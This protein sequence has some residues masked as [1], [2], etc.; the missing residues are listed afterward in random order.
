MKVLVVGSGGRE[1]A[2]AWK[3]AQSPLINQ[4]YVAP[5]NAG[6]HREPKVQN[7]ALSPLAFD[8]LV[9]FVKQ[10]QIDFTVVGPEAPLVEGI[11][12][13]FESKN[14]RC[15]GPSA[16]CAQLEGSKVFSKTFM[17]QFHIP[18]AK[19][20]TFT[21]AKAAEHYLETVNFPIVIKADG[22]ASGKGVIIAPDLTSA[23]AAVFDMLSHKKFGQA[24]SQIIIED[25]IQ[26]E[27]LS[28][29]VL[30]DGEHYL[31]LATSQD[32]KARDDNDKG[33]NTGGM[34]AYSPAPIANEDLQTKIIKTVIEP[35]LH[36]LRANGTPFKG[37]LYAGLMITAQNDIYVL[38]YNCRFG[39]PE[40]QPILMRLKSDFAQLCL[41]T[42][43]GKLDTY[44][45]QWDSQAALGVVLAANG[46]PDNPHMGDPCPTLNEIAPSDNYKIFH[47]GTKVEEGKI[48]IN[49]GRVLC[50]TA[51]GDTIEMAKDNAY[52]I[53]QKA[54]WD[55]VFYR[56]DIGAKAIK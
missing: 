16:A 6:T 33:P 36:G 51:L 1:H 10:N 8:A 49:G 45:A 29:I 18:T 30:C 42:L 22:L 39:D 26:G 20:E 7:I 34:G 3:L 25:F 23:K 15:L 44:Q 41:D 32:H 4:V 31:P 37:F 11:V 46:Y 24:S 14:L 54:A 5:G 13:F 47:A 53:V 9:D 2:L 38:E 19:A 48:V 35:T 12:D 28:F 55:S 21:D 56:K 40:T 50:V 27:E 52:R 43:A 17:H